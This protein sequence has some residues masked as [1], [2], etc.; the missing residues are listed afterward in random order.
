MKILETVKTSSLII[1]AIVVI[2]CIFGISHFG[3]S[4]RYLGKNSINNV[5]NNTTRRYFTDWETSVSVP[6]KDH[7][8][9]LVTDT[10]LE[11]ISEWNLIRRNNTKELQIYMNNWYFD[12]NGERILLQRNNT[13][14]ILYY[15][16]KYPLSAS[17]QQVMVTQG[18]QEVINSYKS[19]WF[20]C[21]KAQRLLKKMK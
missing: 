16:S 17:A 21:Y 18:N 13:E 3:N 15:I 19:Q 14:A 20:M 2:W 6:E 11:R 1:G 4:M 12:N 9:I 5:L 10:P 7:A 8:I